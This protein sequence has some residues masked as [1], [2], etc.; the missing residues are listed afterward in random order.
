MFWVVDKWALT[1][2]W[3]FWCFHAP[4]LQPLFYMALSMNC[5]VCVN[6][7]RAQLN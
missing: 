4:Q 6:L 3:R 7:F 1:N 2:S 5:A